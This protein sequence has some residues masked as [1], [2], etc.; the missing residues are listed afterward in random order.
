VFTPS[1]WLAMQAYDFF[2]IFILTTI[3]CRNS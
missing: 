3:V 2:K 1:I